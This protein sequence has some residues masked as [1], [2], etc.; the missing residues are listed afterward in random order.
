MAGLLPGRLV[1]LAP[2]GLRHDGGERDGRVCPSG[3]SR[4]SIIP[5]CSC[6]HQVI[7]VELIFLGLPGLGRVV[8]ALPA[9][10]AR[11]SPIATLAVSGRSGTQA[12]AHRTTATVS[13]AAILPKRR[14][15][16]PILLQCEA[17]CMK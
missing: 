17:C 16:A 2:C 13:P 4:T 9:W 14:V 15:S 8:P 3:T 5:L 12:Q 10:P 11:P 6:M 1:R 7:N